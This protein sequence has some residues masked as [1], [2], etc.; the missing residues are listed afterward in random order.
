MAKERRKT[1]MCEKH[2]VPCE[3]ECVCVRIYLNGDKKLEWQKGQ[4]EP[5]AI[6]EQLNENMHL[7]CEILELVLGCLNRADGYCCHR[8]M[9][10]AM[11]YTKYT[12]TK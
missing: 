3:C 4:T 7:S 9:V 10:T 6:A 8:M 1:E 11:I 2:R 12:V 5:A